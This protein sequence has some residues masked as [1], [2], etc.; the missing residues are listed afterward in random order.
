MGFRQAIRLACA[1][2]AAMVFFTSLATAGPAEF[3]SDVN[4]AIDAGLVYSRTNNHFTVYTEGNGFSLL[5]LLEQGIDS[6]WL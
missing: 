1:T 6:G 2:A 4:A 5:T 3:K